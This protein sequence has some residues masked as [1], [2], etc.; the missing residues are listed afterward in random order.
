[1]KGEQVALQDLNG[2][3][4]LGDQFGANR[5]P[6]SGGNAVLAAALATHSDIVFAF[7]N[8]GRRRV[9]NNH[10]LPAEQS[11]LTLQ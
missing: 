2:R 5:V 6:P 1:V 10:T 7:I 8:Q 3:S 9:W 11:E 4:V